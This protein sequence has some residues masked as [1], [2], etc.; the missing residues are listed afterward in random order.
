MAP[1]DFYAH[2]SCLN[3]CI[4]EF[5][6]FV[7][8]EIYKSVCKFGLYLSCP[9]EEWKKWHRWLTC[10][11]QTAYL[12]C[13]YKKDNRRSCMTV[14]ILWFFPPRLSCCVYVHSYSEIVTTL[15]VWWSEFLTTNHEVPRSIPGSSICVFPWKGETPMVTMVW[16]ADRN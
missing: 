10:D 4:T 3:Y 8:L 14:E 16:V 12:K 11:P 6:L 7:I 15:V 9:Y 2:I 5:K 13:L 1:K